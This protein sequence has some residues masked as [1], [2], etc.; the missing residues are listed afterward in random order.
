MKKLKSETARWINSRR[1]ILGAL[2]LLAL[3]AGGAAAR[4]HFQS[5][6]MALDAPTPA[7]RVNYDYAVT[8]PIPQ[9]TDLNPARVA[10]G[11]KL[12]HDVRLS[13]DDTV[14]CASCHNLAGGGVDNRS[15]SIGVR[16]A[17]GGINAPTVFNSGLNFVQFWDGRAPT[18]EAQIDGPV[19]HPLEMASNWQQVIGKLGQDSAFV[20]E[21]A[22]LYPGGLSE[23]NIKNAI[24]EFE[25]S[26]LTPNSRFD[27]FLRGDSNAL[28]EQE[29]HGYALFQSYGCSSCHQ[30]VNLGGNMYEKMGL[31]GDYFADRGNPT[32]A[33]K[34]RF[35]VTGNP[36]NLHEFRVPSL[37]N[38]ALTAP[39]FHDGSARTLEGAI[40]VM[41]KYQLGRPMPD[42]DL[43]SIA[44][45]LR[46]LTGQYQGKP[47]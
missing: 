25:R 12:F 40:A 24:A 14:S 34:G 16:G 20:Q 26:L 21:F 4:W 47:L 38:V 15:R 31:M 7:M 30:G 2:L 19:T 36:D 5:A 28:V 41:V 1:P 9:S 13:V 3:L 11:G 43:Q 6:A 35:N 18:L 37:R 44:A 32:E 10:L 27:K 22:K 45:F 8:Q 46:T 23:A 39:Y 42:A 33:D 17:V 29:K